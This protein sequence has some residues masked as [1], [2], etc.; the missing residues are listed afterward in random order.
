LSDVFP[1]ENELKQEDALSPLFFKF[2]SDYILRNVQ[3][4]QKGFGTEWFK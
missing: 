3:G 4:N 1:R 2:A